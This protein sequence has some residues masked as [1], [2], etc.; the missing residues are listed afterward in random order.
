MPVVT[1]GGAIFDSHYWALKCLNMI[2]E[3][4]RVYISV[5]VKTRAELATLRLRN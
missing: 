2:R 1:A 5:C 4:I 3:L